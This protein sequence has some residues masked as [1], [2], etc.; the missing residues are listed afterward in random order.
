VYSAY[1]EAEKV[2]NDPDYVPEI[3]RILEE[4]R[5]LKCP[6]GHSRSFEQYG[7]GIYSCHDCMGGKKFVRKNGVPEW[8]GETTS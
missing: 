2:L 5:R 3:V 1:P 4:K 7:L 6:N 8:I